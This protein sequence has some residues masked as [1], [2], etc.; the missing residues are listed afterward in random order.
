MPS[1]P[2]G[3]LEALHPGNIAIPPCPMPISHLEHWVFDLDNTLYPA[4]ARLFDEI[5]ERM[6]QFMMRELSMDRGEA[7]SLRSAFW[8]QH[9]TT[10]A[11]LMSEYNVDPVRFLDDVHRIDL[12]AIEHDAQLA[13][14]I[15]GLGGQKIIYTNGSRAHGENVSTARGVRQAFDQVFGIEDAHFEPK[16]RRAAF[17]RVFEAAGVAPQKG[18]M[19]E[20]DPRNLQVPHEMGM[21]TVLVGETDPVDHVHHQT[22]DLSAFLDEIAACGFPPR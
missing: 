1:H 21:V 15:A 18:V 13:R 3:R 22:T 6:E 14:Q 19:F 11:G 20:D 7:K 16:P 12:S 8:H 4:T 10:L 5:E 2:F 9:G 17:E